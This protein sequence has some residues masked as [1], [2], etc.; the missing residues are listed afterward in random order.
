MI[1]PSKSI[2]V[3]LT[4]TF[5]DMK[6]ERDTFIRLSMVRSALEQEINVGTFHVEDAMEHIFAF[7]RIL[8]ECPSGN[9][10]YK[11]SDLLPVQKLLSHLMSYFQKDYIVEYSLAFNKEKINLK[12]FNY[13]ITARN[14]LHY[15]GK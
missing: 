4:P 1:I 6:M 13:L 3:F 9:N 7:F 14:L 5:E 12:L 10:K 11:D 8:P 2:R 15:N